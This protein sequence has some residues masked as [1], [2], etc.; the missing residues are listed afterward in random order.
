MEEQQL[1]TVV[2]KRVFDE[3]NRPLLQLTVDVDQLQRIVISNGAP[4]AGEFLLGA[5]DDFMRKTRK[6][7]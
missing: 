4:A 1:N 5:M 3:T 7:G 6:N 2:V